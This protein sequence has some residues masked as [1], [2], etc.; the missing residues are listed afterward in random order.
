MKRPALPGP[1]ER[2]LERPASPM[3][4]RIE[5]RCGLRRSSPLLSTLSL[6]WAARLGHPSS[7][8]LL[9]G[10]RSMSPSVHLYPTG[11]LFKKSMAAAAD[12]V[13][14]GLPPE[15]EAAILDVL[16]TYPRQCMSG[17]RRSR[18]PVLR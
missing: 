14:W 13:R 12:E 17:V 10:W 18:R 15:V 4:L 11:R 16:N 1:T 2:V 5:T 6:E 8:G 3:T 7:Y 9:V